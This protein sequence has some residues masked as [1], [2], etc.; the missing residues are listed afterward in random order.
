MAEWEKGQSYCSP[1]PPRS[2]PVHCAFS[3]PPSSSMRENIA[4]HEPVCGPHSPNGLVLLI[5]RDLRMGGAPDTCV[6]S[7]Q[8]ESREKHVSLV[9][10]VLDPFTHAIF[11]AIFSCDFSCD[12]DAIL[13]TKPAPAYSA[14]VFSRVALRQNTAT[15]WKERCLQMICD[16]VLSNPR[17]ASRQQHS[18]SVG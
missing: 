17:D 18:C 8:G 14:R 7:L 4:G 2:S 10:A 16:N 3:H 6:P 15:L 12:F 1:S 13:C 5:R 9:A 11:H